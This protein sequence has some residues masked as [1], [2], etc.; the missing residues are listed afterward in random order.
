MPKLKYGNT[1]GKGLSY[2][3]TSLLHLCPRKFQ[4]KE[5][6]GLEIAG[7]E[8]A[9]NINFSFGHALAAGV[10]HLVA[11]PGQ[12]ERAVV[13][14]VSAWDGSLFMEDEKSKKSIWFAIR[15]I[16]NFAANQ[17]ANAFFRD[18]EIAWF[19]DR[20]GEL[21]PA[22]E[23]TF[24]IECYDGYTYEGHID[25][26]LKHKKTGQFLIIELKTTKFTNLHE[27]MYKNSSQA[28]GY[29]VVLDAIAREEGTTSSYHVLYFVYKTT[30]IEFQ[31]M[32][33]PKSKLQRANFI[34]SL[35][36]DIEQAQMYENYGIYPQ[37]G[38]NCF[39]FFNPCEYFNSCGFSDTSLKELVA[40]QQAT[41]DNQSSAGVYGVL[42]EEEFDFIFSLDNIRE[43]QLAEIEAGKKELVASGG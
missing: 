36:L 28:L 40:T 19:K 16:Q 1:G 11:Y 43:Q 38:E 17:A 25:L 29:S 2:S 20:N 14:A 27:A 33:F 22:I 3:R 42:E 15:G 8:Q 23:L 39:N 35:I 37:R 21:K 6:F 24:K 34:N 18:Y 10:Q 13:A 41:G 9:E 26:V 7:A 4:L 30:K 5:I 31:E 12:L 32:V